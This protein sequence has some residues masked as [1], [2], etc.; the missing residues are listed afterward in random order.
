[1]QQENRIKK[2]LFNEVSFDLSV[3]DA[4]FWI[5]TYINNTVQDMQLDIA[6]MQK[7]I[8]IITAVH[9]DSSRRFNNIDDRLLDIEKK[10]ERVIT[11]LEK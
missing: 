2:V 10:L 4:V 7:D 8:E 11:L 1:M 3:D 6:I 9:N 5:M